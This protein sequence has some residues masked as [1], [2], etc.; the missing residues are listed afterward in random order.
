MTDI[1][2]IHGDCLEAMR[3]LPDRSVDMVLC[4]LPYG[5]TPCPWDS[6]IAPGP[7]WEHYR[8]LIRGS[9]AIV[10][11]AAQPFTSALVLSNP[12]W[13]RYGWVWEK[14]TGTGYL[15][16]RRR[17]LRCHEDVLV[18]SRGRPPYYPQMTPAKRRVIRRGDS[19]AIY[20]G[21]GRITSDNGGLAYP[22]SVLYVP[23]E[24]AGLHPTQKPVA[25]FEYLVRTYTRP[26][27]LVL[28]NCLGSGTTAAACLNSG[29]RC[30]GIESDEGFYAI[31]R[32]R[33]ASARSPLNP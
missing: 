4:D 17:P 21:S 18:F 24:P 16:A 6:P 2:L 15:D 12:R 23:R 11:T 26:G 31:A 5:L 20:R 33:I 13:F 3:Q 27:E 8:R 25:L 9:G 32:A 10:L 14:S 28:D 1:R 22:R 30:I 19:P 7:L 29:R